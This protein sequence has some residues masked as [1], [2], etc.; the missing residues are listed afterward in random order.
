MMK[1]KT[2]YFLITTLFLL[3]FGSCSTSVEEAKNPTLEH[4]EEDD[5]HVTLTTDQMK[6]V[7]IQVGEIE[8]KE[9]SDVL[10]VTGTLDVPNTNKGYATSLFGGV[11]K[12]LK[13]Q[14]GD[15]VSVGQIIATIE[16]V[17]FVQLQEEFIS[18][19]SQVDLARQ[20]MTRQQEL[21]TGNAGALKNLQAATA[22]LKQLEARQSSLKQQIK[23]MGMNPNQVTSNNIQSSMTVTSPIKGVVSEVYGKIGSYVD[24]SSPLAEIVDNSSLHLDLKIFEKDLPKLK[25]GQIIHF[26]LT[27]NPVKEY[28][29][30]IFSIA[31]SFANASKTI[32]V[33]CDVIGDKTGLID[34]MNVNGIVSLGDVKTPTVPNEAI[35][36]FD[37]KDFIFIVQSSDQDSYQLERIEVIKGVSDMGYTAITFIH[38]LPLTTKIISKGAFFV[39]AKLTNTGE[40]EH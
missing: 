12:T 23:M 25:I 15:H 18:V 40:H 5:T 3:G 6:S 4:S 27:N 32:L 24:V 2:T 36:H 35:V 31:S 7:D 28:D 20:E 30:E 10:R 38:E 13:V 19:G 39:N 21:N 34:G 37:G 14:V 33:H 1:K 26:T 8:E 29:A 22:N 9:L 11:V 17:Q 16:N